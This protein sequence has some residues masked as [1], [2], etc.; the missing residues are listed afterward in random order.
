MEE[1]DK[2]A[3]LIGVM[4]QRMLALGTSKVLQNR[5]GDAW[6]VHLVLRSAPHTIKEEM[7][8]VRAWVE[9]N[10]PGAEP[11]DVTVAQVKMEEGDRDRPQ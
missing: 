9:A 7:G 1:A 6:M 10:I 2:L 3:T 4:K 11:P 5:W 8:R